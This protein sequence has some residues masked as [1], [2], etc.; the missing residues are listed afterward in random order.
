MA[1]RIKTLRIWQLYPLSVASEETPHNIGM[2]IPEGYD[3]INLARALL[4]TVPVESDGSVHFV[5]PSGVEA[6]LPGHR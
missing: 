6:L 5:A 1:T 2:Q 4:G 3:S